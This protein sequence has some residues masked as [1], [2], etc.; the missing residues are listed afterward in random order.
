MDKRS[1]KKGL[2][3]IAQL[4]DKYAEIMSRTMLRYAIEHLDRTQK[5]YY[6]KLKNHK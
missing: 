1:R 5:D 3:Q 6:M 4:L 2:Y